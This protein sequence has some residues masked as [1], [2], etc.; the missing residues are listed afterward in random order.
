MQVFKFILIIC[1]VLSTTYTPYITADHAQKVRQQT[2]RNNER[3]LGALKALESGGRKKTIGDNGKAYGVLQIHRGAVEDVNRVFQKQYTH[4]QMFDTDKAEEVF[5]Y[6]TLI[7]IE[8][9]RLKEC[10]EADEQ[11][12]VRNWNG[13]AY[14]GW[15]RKSTEKYFK[16]YLQ[17]LKNDIKNRTLG[18]SRK[19][20]YRYH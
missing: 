17:I 19:V 5:Y 3:V 16:K 4:E 15:K 9:I 12:I 13:G 11:D 2:N 8:Q 10:R 7:G 6:Y 14:S 1:T 20:T 18:E